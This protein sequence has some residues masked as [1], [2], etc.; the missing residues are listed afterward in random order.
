M[1]TETMEDILRLFDHKVQLE[2][3]QIIHFFENAF[4]QAETLQN[5]FKN[6]KLIFLPKYAT[7]RWQ[8]T[9][10]QHNESV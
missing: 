7:F 6:I 10:R 8:P 2:P 1:R 5:N 9:W 3:R 4:F